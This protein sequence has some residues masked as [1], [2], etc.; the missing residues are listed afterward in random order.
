ML[1]DRGYDDDK[2]R[3]L[4]RT[5]GVKLVIARRGAENGPDLAPDAGR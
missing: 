4:V 3:R 1:G 5:L 2:Y